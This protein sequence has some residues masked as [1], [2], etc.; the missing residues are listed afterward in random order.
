MGINAFQAEEG[1]A[2]GAASQ[3]GLA[4]DAA[5]GGRQLQSGQGGSGGGDG[6]APPP[7]PPPRGVPL[8]ANPLR[9]LGSALDSWRSRLAVSVEAPPPQVPPPPSLKVFVE[10]YLLGNPNI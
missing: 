3:A 7:P 9:S 2:E 5:G 10:T 8:E 4:A 1:A 6:S